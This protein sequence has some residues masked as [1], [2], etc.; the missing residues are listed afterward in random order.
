MSVMITFK[1][2]IEFIVAAVGTVAFSILFS[3]HKIATRLCEIPHLLA[4]SLAEIYSIALHS[5]F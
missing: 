5:L 4:A 1:F 2:W 3:E